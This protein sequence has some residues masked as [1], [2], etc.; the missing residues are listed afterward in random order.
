VRVDN[1]FEVQM[2]LASYPTPSSVDPFSFAIN[3][4]GCDQT[5]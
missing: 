2:A 1:E 5:V 4:Q 3:A